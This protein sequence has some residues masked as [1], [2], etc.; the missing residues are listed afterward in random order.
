MLK[1]K[2]NKVL[3][4]GFSLIELLFVLVIISILASFA[5]ITFKDYKDKAYVTQDGML[6]A[7]NCMGDLVSYCISNPGKSVDPANMSSCQP[8]TSVFGNITFTVEAS[9]FDCLNTGELPENYTIIVRSS[10]TDK[11]Y[12]KCIY[13]QNKHAYKCSVEPSF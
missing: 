4:N 7:K 3:R 8:T 2:V 13:R 6:L 5:I 10:I 9:K 11:F 1:I 12:V